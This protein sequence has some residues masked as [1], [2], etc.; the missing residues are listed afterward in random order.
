M[1]CDGCKTPPDGRR[2]QDKTLGFVYCINC[3][4][5]KKASDMSYRFA[6]FDGNEFDASDPA[7]WERVGN[8][9]VNEVIEAVKGLFRKV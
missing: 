2:W 3:V 5:K 7:F 9:S 4:D 6:G 1:R 8:M